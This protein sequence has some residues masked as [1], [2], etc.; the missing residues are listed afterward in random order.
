MNVCD[1]LNSIKTCN[2]VQGCGPTCEP[3]DAYIY[4][5]VSGD[6]GCPCGAPT[7]SP[8][9]S[10]TLLN[11]RSICKFVSQNCPDFACL[12]V[13]TNTIVEFDFNRYCI[14]TTDVSLDKIVKLDFCVDGPNVNVYIDIDSQEESNL[15]QVVRNAMLNSQSVHHHKIINTFSIM[16]LFSTQLN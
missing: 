3:C 13:D 16:D 8:I 9:G 6:C 7:S 11:K 10:V 14:D 12:P 5:N 4:L 15:C 2:E 1:F